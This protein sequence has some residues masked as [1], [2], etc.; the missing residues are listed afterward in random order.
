MTETR[1]AGFHRRSRR[2]RDRRGRGGHDVRRDRGRAR[3]PRAARSTT[4][5]K[6]GEKIRISGGGRCNFTNLHATHRDFLSRNP[7]FCRSALARYTP[8]RFHRARGAPRHRL[9]REDAGAALL[10]RELAAD[11]RHAGGG[12]PR[13]GVDLAAALRGARS[14]ARGRC[15][16]SRPGG[17]RARAPRSSIATGGLTVPKIGA[18]PFG[19]RV[20]EQ[21]GLAVV[22]AQ[23]RAGPAHLRPRAARALR[24]PRGR[25]A[26]C[27]GVRA[28]ADDFARACSSRTA[29]F[30]VRRSCRSRR[31]GRRRAR[32][33]RST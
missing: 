28:Q 11:H 22:R 17:A 12:V 9:P 18:T 26:R 1:I 21:F 13:G 16:A 30:P 14:C 6:V 19:Y 10:R 29:A 3:A 15:F 7:D 32:R 8:R 33:S 4:T 25:L 24:R 31:I 2:G 5:P 23:A 20:A 27:R